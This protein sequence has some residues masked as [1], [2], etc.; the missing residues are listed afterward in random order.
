MS[1][2][3]GQGSQANPGG[4]QGA[5]PIG[6]GGTTTSQSAQ[7]GSSQA[8]NQG[9]N[10]QAV[11]V[12]ALLS[13]IETLE[14]EGVKARADAAKYRTKLKALASD[15]S[16]SQGGQ[17][18]NGQGGLDPQTQATIKALRDGRVKDQLT[19]AAEKAGASDPS[20]IWRFVDMDTVAGDDG[21]VSQPEKLMADLRKSYPYM[22]KPVVEGSADGGGGR[23]TNEKPGDMNALIRNG[24]RSLRGQA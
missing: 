19:L 9:T 1:G 17:G 4:G 10:T 11:D 5:N 8:E 2:T 6:D 18:A 20:N 3:E 24:F 23:S 16:D 12:S 22:F 7:G 21:S 15:D 14:K 13:R